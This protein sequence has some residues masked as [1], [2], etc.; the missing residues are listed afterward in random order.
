MVTS[1]QLS[2]ARDAC[3]AVEDGFR[4]LPTSLARDEWTTKSPQR[5]GA[6][7]EMLLRMDCV[8]GRVDVSCLRARAAFSSRKAWRHFLEELV[9]R[10]YI[11]RSHLHVVP[12]KPGRRLVVTVVDWSQFLP[13]SGSAN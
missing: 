9:R 3:R 10:E 7:L 13:D 5:L 12:H 1:G 11:K 4:L 6:W 2:P 8:T